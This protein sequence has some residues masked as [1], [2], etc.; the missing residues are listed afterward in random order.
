[1]VYDTLVLGLALTRTFIIW[2]QGGTGSLLAVFSRDHI[3]S[4]S[5]CFFAN[6]ANVVSRKRLPA[7]RP[8]FL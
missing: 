5:L 6:L 1:M 4:F 8:L 7:T 2:K 3:L